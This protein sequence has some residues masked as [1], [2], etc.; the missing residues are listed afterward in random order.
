MEKEI[1]LSKEVKILLLK[2]LKSGKL[3]QKDA[4]VLINFMQTGDLFQRVQINFK[5]FAKESEK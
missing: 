3:S 4:D 5:D 2:I 1:L